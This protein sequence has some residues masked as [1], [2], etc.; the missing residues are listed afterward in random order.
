MGRIVEHATPLFLALVGLEYMLAPHAFRAVDT[1]SSLACGA[2]EVMTSAALSTLFEW[3]FLAMRGVFKDLGI[4]MHVTSWFGLALVFVATDLAYYCTHRTAHSVRLAWSGHGV[5]HS[6]E[7]YNL[8]TA[9]RQSVFEKMFSTAF[10]LPLALF[11][12]YSVWRDLFDMN[13]CYQFWVHTS[14]IKKMPV[15][16][17]YVFVTPSHHRVHHARNP[18]YIDRN[19][20]GNFIIW[21]RLFGTYAQEDEQCV[22]GLVHPLQSFNTGWVQTHLLWD[23][24]YMAWITPGWGDKI[25][26]LL[27]EPGWDPKT[28]R[29]LPLPPVDPK[30]KKFGPELSGRVR[31]WSLLMFVINSLTLAHYL[32][33]HRSM[34]SSQ[35]LFW[36]ALFLVQTSWVGHVTSTARK[37]PLVADCARLLLA[38][39]ILFF[40][41]HLPVSIILLFVAPSVA[42]GIRAFGM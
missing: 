17:E 26:V 33:H 36:I 3:P 28:K 15:W 27:W 13:L 11:V 4:A 38:C 37:V 32:L 9:L 1:F 14:V 20:G 34:A 25:R 41:L 42:M 6:S 30:E 2:V 8:T 39:A 19:Y 12:E 35:R 10:W 22:Y 40:G 18:Q 7:E 24:L 16:F 21:D 5:H 29:V 23:A 31:Q